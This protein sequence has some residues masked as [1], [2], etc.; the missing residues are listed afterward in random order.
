MRD[1]I[2][3]GNFYPNNIQLGRYDASYGLLLTGGP[4][5]ALSP[6]SPVSSGISLRGQVR[7]L[8]EINIAGRKYLL[9]VR[10]NDTVQV[11]SLRH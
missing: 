9:G 5:T 8:L 7:K 3:A 1:L 4:G 6:W 2:V 10:N 11:F